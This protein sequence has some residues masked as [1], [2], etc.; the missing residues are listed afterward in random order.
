MKPRSGV[1]MAGWLP[2]DNLSAEGY[3]ARRHPARNGRRSEPRRHALCRAPFYGES[4][5]IMYRT[6]LME[7]LG[8]GNA[9]APTWTFIAKLLRR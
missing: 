2:L 8:L 1:P 9:E 7:R 6:D 3:D 4:S 5:M